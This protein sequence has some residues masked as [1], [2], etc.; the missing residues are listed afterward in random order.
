MQWILQPNLIMPILEKE[1]LFLIMLLSS[2]V[3]SQSV[4]DQMG[5]DYMP[6]VSASFPMTAGMYGVKIGSKC[7]T[8]QTLSGSLSMGSQPG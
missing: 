5:Q 4:V 6:K 3:G 8:A 7:C 2:Q 1:A